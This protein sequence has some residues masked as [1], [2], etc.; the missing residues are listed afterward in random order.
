MTHEVVPAN[1]L[2]ANINLTEAQISAAGASV[3]P[4]YVVPLSPSANPD[5]KVGIR[6]GVGPKASSTVSPVFFEFDT[7]G[8]GFWASSQALDQDFSGCVKHGGVYNQ[9]DS[10]ITYIGAATD[11][12]VTLFDA[13]GPATEPVL[14]TV[15]L[16][17]E[18]FAL[19]KGA[20]RTEE[21]SQFPIFPCG[22]SNG[23]EFGFWGDFGA[24]LQAT[25]LNAPLKHQLPK[26]VIVPVETCQMLTVL[27][28]LPY[29]NGPGFIV[30]L[31]NLEAAPTDLGLPEGSRVGR[32]ILGGMNTLGAY[33]ATVF[34]LVSEGGYVSPATGLNYQTFSEAAG[35][36]DVYVEAGGVTTQASG[37]GFILDTGAPVTTF[38]QTSA[39]SL[40][41]KPGDRVIISQQGQISLLDYVVGDIPG[42]NETNTQPTTANAS[43]NTGLAPYFLYPVAFELPPAAQTVAVSGG[44][45]R[46]A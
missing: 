37:I 40:N 29:N 39:F 26:N 12:Y 45:L 32:L 36:G 4:L 11:V 3:I 27:S 35:S 9:Y 18:I 43:V 1:L 15:G 13:N 2:P 33:F 23:S 41:P 6:V 44:F 22:G 7:G 34:P 30:D 16:V 19:T 21:A 10:G 5:Y 31:A 17:D 28:Q 14:A 8:K 24:S 20:V 42:T 38:H 46:F 25:S